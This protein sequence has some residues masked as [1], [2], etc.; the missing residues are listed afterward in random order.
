MPARKVAAL[1]RR[2][3]VHAAARFAVA[4][5]FVVADSVVPMP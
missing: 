2:I 5:F 1:P 4:A 3:R